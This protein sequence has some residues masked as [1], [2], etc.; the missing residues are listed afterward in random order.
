MRL[1]FP[2]VFSLCVSLRC[3]L[4]F[5]YVFSSWFS[6]CFPYV[7][8]SVFQRSS[9]SNIS[10]LKRFRNRKLNKRFKFKVLC[11][12][13]KT[14]RFQNRQVLCF[15]NKTKRFQNRQV[16]NQ[17]PF[18]ET[19]CLTEG[20]WYILVGSRPSPILPASS[21]PHPAR[22]RISLDWECRQIGNIARF[23][24]PPDWE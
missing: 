20:W 1:F 5:P 13:N 23:R 19:T 15:R 11:F 18:L 4:C 2:Y 6:L 24:S 12:R 21:A 22:L 16:K 7:F 14:K 10:K 17:Y 3:S 9:V 8:R